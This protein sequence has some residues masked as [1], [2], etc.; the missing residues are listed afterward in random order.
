MSENEFNTNQ[1]T[2]VPSRPKKQDW[3]AEWNINRVSARLTKD[4][5]H[6][7]SLYRQHIAPDK[8]TSEALND[9]LDDYLPHL[10]K[11]L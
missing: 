3:K 5:Y 11:T 6:R 4:V 8:N 1:E 9:I 2:H 10:P 7:F